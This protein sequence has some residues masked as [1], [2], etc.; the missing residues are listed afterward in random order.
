M[1]K[2]IDTITKFIIITMTL[3]TPILLVFGILTINTPDTATPEIMCLIALAW[4][5]F[6]IHSDSKS[7]KAEATHGKNR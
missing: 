6:I 2:F 4:L 7:I 5:G 3:L 1:E